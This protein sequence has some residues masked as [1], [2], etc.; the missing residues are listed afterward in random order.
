M[1]NNKLKEKVLNNVKE[2][3]ALSNIRDEINIKSLRNK[4]IFYSTLPTCAMIFVC[5]IVVNSLN[6]EKS[7][8]RL[9]DFG[10]KE[11]IV[12]KEDGITIP[13]LE[14]PNSI[15]DKTI[16]MCRAYLLIQYGENR[17]I[18]TDIIDTDKAENLKGK[19]LGEIKNV[20]DDYLKSDY[21]KNATSTGF[22]HLED[23]IEEQAR[24]NP[25]TIIG[26]DIGKVYEMNGYSPLFRIC[27]IDEVNNQIQIY[28]RLN[29]ITLKYGKDLYEDRLKL[30]R[31]L[32]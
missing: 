14:F 31:K 25:N 26:D 1:E 21:N 7:A 29:G 28:E 27:K 5:A 32:Q 4:K 9:E 2:N 12:A 10:A 6:Q 17:Y 3:I 22:P 24:K 18:S 15:E 16:E 8:N 23:F 13:K 11:E 19:Y 20:V 30:K